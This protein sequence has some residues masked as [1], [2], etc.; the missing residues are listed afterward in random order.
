MPRIKCSF[1]L[2]AFPVLLCAQPPGYKFPKDSA[3]RNP[4]A[5]DKVIMNE[6]ELMIVTDNI[7]GTLTS[8]PVQHRIYNLSPI[9][10]L[11]PGPTYNSAVV[12]EG[13]RHLF[14]ATGDFMGDEREEVVVAWQTGQDIYISI[15]S[16]DVPAFTIGST[17]TT[18]T[19]PGPLAAGS[20]GGNAGRIIVRA[21]DLDA[22]GKDEFAT[23]YRNANDGL[24]HI[25]VFD[26]DSATGN[27]TH[28]GSIADEPLYVLNATSY[29][30]FDMLADDLDFDAVDELILTGTQDGAVNQNLFCKI[31]IVDGSGS[32]FTIT[33]KAKNYIDNSI[34]RTKMV[35]IKATTG[36]F[37]GDLLSEIAVSYNFQLD[38]YPSAN[39]DTYIKV[40]SAADS[41]ATSPFQPDYT[42]S[43]IVSD[44][45]YTTNQNENLLYN[46]SIDAADIDMDGHDE[47]VVSYDGGASRVLKAGDDMH[48][49]LLANI[50]QS[51]VNASNPLYDNFMEVSD[52]NRDGFYDIINVRNY[53]DQNSNPYKQKF[54]ITIH[55]WDTASA[56]FVLLTSMND[57]DAVDESNGGFER[58]FT[59]ALGDF[60]LDRVRFGKP[61]QSIYSQLKHPLVILNSPP[62]HFDT[63][64]TGAVTD[65]AGVYPSPPVNDD[66]KAEYSTLT[67]Q[68]MT[69]QT[70]TNSD[71]KASA[72]LELGASIS[73]LDIGGS[74]KKKFGIKFSNTQSSVKSVSVATLNTAYTDDLIYGWIT[75]Y[76][77]YEYPVFVDDSVI[78]Y[79]T[80]VVPING[81]KTWFGGTEQLGY[82]VILNHEPGNILSYPDYNNLIQDPDIKEG[83]KADF[84]NTY[85]VGPSASFQWGMT[86]S[87]INSQ[88]T[89]TTVSSGI[90]ASLKFE[91]FDQSLGLE[92]S[93]DWSQT[94][95]YT[96]TIQSD[97]K[98]DISVGPL[99]GGFPDP[100]YRINPYLVWSN[101]GSV[102]LNYS[103][104]PE[105]PATG[106]PST[107]WW[108]NYQVQDPALLLPWRLFPEKGFPLLDQEKRTLS[109]SIWLSKKNPAPGDTVD[110]NVGVFN[111]SVSPTTGPV[112]VNL[113]LGNPANGGMLMT[114]T[115]GQTSVFTTG[116]LIKQGRETVKFT[117][118][119][120]Q[121][122]LP[123]PRIFAVLDPHQTMT[124]VHEGNNLG[125]IPLGINYPIG[126]V[127]NS[128][129]AKGILFPNPANDHATLNVILKNSAR[130]HLELYDVMGSRVKDLDENF[131]N[132]GE[133]YIPLNLSGVASGLYICKAGTLQWKLIICR[134]ESE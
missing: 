118:V 123:D 38:N 25:D 36:D 108:T 39:P 61:R 20:G 30:S 132:A 93:Y 19:L 15:P 33:P 47:I 81:Q 72:E 126:I 60:D 82:E 7:T 130:M 66:F 54:D 96:N 97:I 13:N 73:E 106:F 70:E 88:T 55:S 134:N 85:S 68:S 11:L 124:E 84:S 16:I 110:I 29:E 8:N 58:Q 50:G 95:T 115:T 21:C 119:A 49:S 45:L 127:E 65:I 34:S 92:G 71:W 2:L 12:N 35:Y 117:W 22:D 14:S 78:G 98:F 89:D 100:N 105:T 42:E 77:V 76:L 99:A 28:A 3:D 23:A 63:L 43:L 79:I 17:V 102:T 91:A 104:H 129:E 125:W 26:V 80:S 121:G 31:Y 101:D 52:M 107:W 133:H 9:P 131:Y 113:Y 46:F 69:L 1:I 56:S 40:L 103:V 24:I 111:F 5:R 44:E 83:I 112:E 90:E 6:Q 116:P 128:V 32:A 41:T 10:S 114:S 37:N 53:I 18:Y 57:I 27:I 48:F 122:V 74:I 86:F 75:D 67:A 94:S 62:V 120:P 59:I 4:F 51:Y 109:K 87:E 64:E